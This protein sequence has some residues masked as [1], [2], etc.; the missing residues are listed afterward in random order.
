MIAELNGQHVR[1]VK[2]KGRFEWHSHENEDEMF[3]V[4]RG[5]FDML[6][7]EKTVTLNEGEMI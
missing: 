5:S 2:F 4:I 1:V 3:L 7:R 6:F